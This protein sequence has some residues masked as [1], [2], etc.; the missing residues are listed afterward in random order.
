VDDHRIGPWRGEAGGQDKRLHEHH[1]KG[2]II[3]HRNLIT[4]TS[5][6]ALFLGF[7]GYGASSQAQEGDALCNVLLDG[8]GEPVKKEDSNLV[9][10]GNSRACEG[11]EQVESVDAATAPAPVAA[12]V[13]PEPVTVAPL[14]VYFDSGSDSLSPASA[15]KVRDFAD[16]LGASDAK[17]LQVVGYTDT[18]GPADLNQKLSEARTANVIAA[19]IDAGVPASLISRN[20][21]GER[22]LA[23][24]TPDGTQEPNNRRVTVTPNL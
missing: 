19:L 23:V 14:T 13:P 21:A 1:K 9:G 10:H 4:L 3:M 5:V 11:D 24:D 22:N 16:D 15:A 8:D 6:L 2:T 7:A 17:T 20:S 12:V 18:T